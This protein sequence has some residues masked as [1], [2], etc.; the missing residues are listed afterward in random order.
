MF[1]YQSGSWSLD[2]L[3]PQLPTQNLVQLFLDGPPSKKKSRFRRSAKEIPP[4][5][6][7]SSRHGGIEATLRIVGDSLYRSTATIRSETRKGNTILDLVS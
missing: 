6:K 1:T 4:T 5:A 3:A 2:P 7:F